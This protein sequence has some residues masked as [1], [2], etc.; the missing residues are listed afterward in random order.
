MKKELIA[1]I[2]AAAV[3]MGLI[4]VIGLKPGD[5]NVGFEKVSDRK[6]PRQLDAEILPEY[7]DLER[8]LACKVGN[9]IYVIVTRGTKPTSGY[10]VEIDKIV[11]KSEKNKSKMIVYATFADPAD[12]ENMAQIE[13]YPSAVVKTDLEGLPTEIQLKTEFAEN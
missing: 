12:A 3:L 11:I 6:I 8:A 4:F 1:V 2:L 10:D 5:M 9:K 7:R 13:T